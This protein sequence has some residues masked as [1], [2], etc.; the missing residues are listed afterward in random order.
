MGA[1]SELARLIRLGFPEEVA[2][3]I[4]SGELDMSA[5]AR[6]ARARE[7]GYEDGFY[8]GMYPY[9]WTKESGDYKGP[10]ISEINRQSP[11]PSFG[12]ADGDVD[13]AGFMT[14]DPEVANRF[15]NPNLMRNG[16]V[17]PLMKRSNAEHVIDAAGANA[18]DIQFGESGRPFRDA[19]R[20]GEYDTVKIQNTGDEGDVYVALDPSMIRSTNAAFDPQYKGP[21]ILG[22][23]AL[24]ATGAAAL[25]AGSDDA[26]AGFVTRGGK[27]ILEAWHGS[28][29]K[30]DRFSMDSIGTGEGAQAYGHGLYFADS[31]GVA[32]GYRDNLSVSQNGLD[33]SATFSDNPVDS[34]AWMLN[35]GLDESKVREAI[36]VLDYEGSV[37]ELIDA[38]KGRLK[39]AKSGH[40]YRVEVDVTPDQL[41]DW[42]RPLSDET[43]NRLKSLGVDEIMPK[44]WSIEDFRQGQGRAKELT[45]RKLWETLNLG[46]MQADGVVRSDPRSA[47]PAT[48]E[49]LKEAGIKGIK[50]LDGNSRA[51]GDGS[52]NYVIFDDNLINIAERGNAT[53]EMMMALALGSGGATAAASEGLGTRLMN[54]IGDNVTEVLD[55]LEVPQRGLQGLIR[56]GYGLTQGEGLEASLM[57]GADV[58]ENGVEAAAKAAGDKVLEETGS[59]ELAAMAYTA[60]ILGSPI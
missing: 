19:V 16:A 8:K 55:L 42:D 2:K 28:P 1:V 13:I 54:H 31:K 17:F 11:F 32:T 33:G 6:M 43:V 14:K 53:P 59:P 23:Y 25:A 24:P 10:V 20:S 60:T 49:W 48:A 52:S 34:T 41:L 35:S 56:A 51:A 7:Q 30:F 57:A 22:Q 37:D 36:G 46:G 18:G 44:R 47:A 50:Y 40:L 12:G 29:H 9:D 39:Q 26:D 58:V 4:A 5:E 15:A 27:E 38:A 3:R 45:G 21:N